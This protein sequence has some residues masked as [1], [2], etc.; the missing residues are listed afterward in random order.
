MKWTVNLL[1]A[2]KRSDRTKNVFKSMIILCS[3]SFRFQIS[4]FF[5]SVLGDLFVLKWLLDHFEFCSYSIL[6][7]R[8][9]SSWLSLNLCSG[10]FTISHIFPKLSRF[11]VQNA[12]FHE[13]HE[14]SAVERLFQ[15]L[16][17][18]HH[19]LFLISNKWIFEKTD[20]PESQCSNAAKSDAYN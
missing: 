15:K 12:S 10:Y 20:K 19:L 17:T 14:V 9:I 2:I 5:V 8:F 3:P 11:L 16:P 4:S 13:I 6:H 7:R 1:W 18:L